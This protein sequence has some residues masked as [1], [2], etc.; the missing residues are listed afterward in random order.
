MQK[1]QPQRLLSE[2]HST[3]FFLNSLLAERITW[4]ETIPLLFGC[5]DPIDEMIL[6]LD[7]TYDY[8]QI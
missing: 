5:K 1:K 6:S 2:L 4:Y 8:V 7:S 3:G